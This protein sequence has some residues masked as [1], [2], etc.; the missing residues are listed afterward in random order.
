MCHGVPAPLG[1]HLV[2][3]VTVE[4]VLGFGNIVFPRRTKRFGGSKSILGGI[5]IMATLRESELRSPDLL[6]GAV[7][8][9]QVLGTG[10]ADG[11]EKLHQS[12]GV[13]PVLL[14][15]RGGLAI[16]IQISRVV[17]GGNGD[18]GDGAEAK[19]G[20][21]ELLV[22]E[23]IGPGTAR[24]VDGLSK[25]WRGS[26]RDGQDNVLSLAS[27]GFEECA[28]K[29]RHRAVTHQ[30]VVLG[31]RGIPG[32]VDVG[33]VDEKADHGGGAYALPELDR[34]GRHGRVR[35]C[36]AAILRVQRVWIVDR[37]FLGLRRL[38]YGRLGETRC[39]RLDDEFTRAVERIEREENIRAALGAPG[40]MDELILGCCFRPRFVKPH[41][42]VVALGVVVG[43]SVH[44]AGER[45]AKG[46]G[47]HEGMRHHGEE[48]RL[49]AAADSQ[50]NDAS[51][52][53]KFG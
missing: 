14:Q 23:K 43:A 50:Q 27:R 17:D 13:R 7:Q 38:R 45:K 42:V 16:G 15:I 21:Q 40:E 36:F 10:G 1:R 53:R 33:G 20:R 46:A 22:L 19:D 28:E 9:L 48:D 29:A 32:F 12:R 5:A 24:L 30:G 18:D 47:I 2:V 26:L 3:P 49:S 52:G 11:Q 51:T 31:T 39:E 4:I 6:Q 41:L 8:R 25:A 34:I 35:R 37:P 44:V